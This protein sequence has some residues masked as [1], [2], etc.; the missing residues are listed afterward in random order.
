LAAI[1]AA[2]LSVLCQERGETQTALAKATGCSQQ[3]LS[4][5][6]AG[7]HVPGGAAIV[8]I[9]K[10]FG[11]SADWLLGLS[12]ERRPLVGQPAG[13][14]DDEIYRR[15]LSGEKLSGQ[16]LAVPFPPHARLVDRAELDRILAEVDAKPTPKGLSWGRLR[17]RTKRAP[18]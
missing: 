8:A 16:R 10:H 2:R 9:A 3:A 14:V 15:W 7:S 13:M 1:F 18:E 11:V 12:P 4:S 6:M 5:F 17:G